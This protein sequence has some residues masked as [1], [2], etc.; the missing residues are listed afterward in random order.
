M[1]LKKIQVDF[2]R[3]DWLEVYSSGTE[4][5]ITGRIVWWSKSGNHTKVTN[6]NNHLRRIR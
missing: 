3:V 4:L 6:R 2:H 1:I 5:G